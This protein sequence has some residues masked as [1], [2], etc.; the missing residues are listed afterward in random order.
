M[1][2]LCCGKGGDLPFKWKQAKIAH[3]IGSDLSKES[4][5]SAKEK[6]LAIINDSRM[7]DRRNQNTNFPAIFVVQDAGDDENL[8][9][10]ILKKE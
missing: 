5:K 6:Y 2:D 3:Y 9:D 8:L 10:D 4:I 1:L 7:G